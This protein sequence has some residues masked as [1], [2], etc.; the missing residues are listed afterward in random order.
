LAFAIAT[1]VFFINRRLGFL[2]LIFGFAIAFARVFI[3]AH[4]PADVLGG[5][6]LG[7]LTAIGIWWIS[8]TP[9]IDTLIERVFA[10]LARGHL[11][12]SN[13]SGEG[14]SRPRQDARL[15]IP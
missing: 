10:L 8:E 2:L 14:L 13:A 11:A 15:T 1:T 7:G 3:G 12:A 5:A 6:A 4:Y 9:R